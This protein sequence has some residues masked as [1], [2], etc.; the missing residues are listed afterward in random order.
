MAERRRYTKGQKVVAITAAL[1]SS[2]K[3]AAEDQ[4]IPRTTL[5]YW[6]D[7]P[8][9]ATLRQK[10]TADLAEA[11][12]VVAH[13]ATEQLIEAMRAGKVEPRDLIVAMGVGSDKRQ[14]LSGNATSRTETRT[15]S[16]SLNDHEKQQFRDALDRLSTE[17]AGDS[18]GSVPVGAGTEVRE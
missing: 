15:L 3:A 16:D 4:G 8:Q 12:G 9:F 18:E 11:M 2:V 5:T 1:A 7:D 6:L 17:L 14:L 13:V 10:T